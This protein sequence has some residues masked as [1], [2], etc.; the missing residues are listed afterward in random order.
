MKN[1]N[2][3]VANW[4]L[5]QGESE[6]ITLAIEEG[7]TAVLDD[8]QARKCATVLNV[9]LMGTLGLLL[10]SKRK[11]VVKMKR[12]MDILVSFFGL[13]FLSPVLAVWN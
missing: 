9:K 4:N 3:L 13:L 5:G 10:L 11:G 6:V 2:P 12:L 1:I 7:S 8:L